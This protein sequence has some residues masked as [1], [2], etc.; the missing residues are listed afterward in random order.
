[1]TKSARKIHDITEKLLF[2][3]LKKDSEYILELFDFFTSLPIEE[4]HQG[5]IS[6]KNG[7]ALSNKNASDCIKDYKRTAT[8]LRGTYKSIM[9]STKRFP[10]IRL[11][12]L[13]AGCGPYATLLVPLLSFFEPKNINITLID[14]N[15]SSIASVKNLI[16]KLGYEDYISDI[17]VADATQFQYP[18]NTPLHVVV[19][20]TMFH[21][22]T[23][24]P[25]VAITQNLAPQLTEGGL[26]IPEEITISLGYSFFSKEPY[27]NQYDDTYQIANSANKNVKRETINKLFSLNK[28]ERTNQKDLLHFFESKWHLIPENYEETPDI[29]IYTH[30]K[31]FDTFQLQDADSLITNPYCLTSL[32]NLQDQNKFKI[33]YNTQNIPNWE[34]TVS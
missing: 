32:Y 8:F 24:E 34:I 33:K 21:A 2:S 6:L 28:N 16:S 27:L 5:D 30:I 17:I 18:K 1:M 12:I 11:N 10:N 20:E 3:P 22:L 26:L 19:T 4:D 7:I 13:Y 31:I 9:E 29:C 23:K 15:Q 25:Q 14:I